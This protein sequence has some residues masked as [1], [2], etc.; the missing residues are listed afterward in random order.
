MT[1]QLPPF[2]AQ[3]KGKKKWLIVGLATA[4]AAIEA[5]TLVGLLP[6][7]AALVRPVLE[8]VAEAVE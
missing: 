4:I 5:A 6:R 3:P 2:E 1:T 7:A 8:A